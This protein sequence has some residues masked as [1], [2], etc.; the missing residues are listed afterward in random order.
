LFGVQAF[1]LVEY[2]DKDKNASEA[3]LPVQAFWTRVALG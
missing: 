3:V 2:V 1:E